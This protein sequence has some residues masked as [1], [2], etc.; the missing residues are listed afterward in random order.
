MTTPAVTRPTST[1]PLRVAGVL[2]IVAGLASIAAN[3]TI[4]YAESIHRAPP[5]TFG[6]LV[7]IVPEL[8]AAGIASLSFLVAFILMFAWQ[9]RFGWQLLFLIAAF[10]YLL[11]A[12]RFLNLGGSIIGDL[13]VGV[14][15]VAA[16]LNVFARNIF[17]RGPSVL[18][19]ITMVIAQLPLV[20]SI[21]APQP[22]A[23]IFVSEYV[24]AVLYV[25][26]GV[27][28]IRG[29]RTRSTATE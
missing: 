3:A 1:R 12:T 21:F 18:F 6:P 24:I 22:D 27:A 9:P 11:E 17:T 25:V 4:Q 10:G 15:T 2:F 19:L 13:V 5:D 20:V 7:L 28:M 29:A 14:G 8:A 26:C 23:V 16:G